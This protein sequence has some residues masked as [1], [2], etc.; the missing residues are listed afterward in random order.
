VR[1]RTR[2]VAAGEVTVR[3][4]VDVSVCRGHDP[5]VVEAPEVF[6][7]DDGGDLVVAL[8]AIGVAATISSAPPRRTR[9]PRSRTRGALGWEAL[10]R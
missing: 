4:R 3:V 5:C 2:R 7:L 6:S 9:W 10:G 1:L 8:E